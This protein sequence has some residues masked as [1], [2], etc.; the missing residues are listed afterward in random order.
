[1][2]LAGDIEREA[3]AQVL[4]ESQLDP[5][6][7]GR[8]DVLKVAH[9][10]SSN[11][12]DRILD[13]VDGRLALISVGEGNDYGHPAPATMKALAGAGGSRCTAPTSRATSRS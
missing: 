7:W 13:H 3:A 11:R 9:H 1:M 4:H 5:Q 2:L 12:D 8:I 10:G 6:R